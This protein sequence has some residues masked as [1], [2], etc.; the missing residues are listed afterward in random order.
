LSV[1]PRLPR[2]LETLDEGWGDEDDSDLK[3]PDVTP[4]CATSPRR[5]NKKERRELERK[6]RAEQAK[7]EQQRRAARKE[8]KKAA[9]TEPL[10]ASAEPR[11]VADPTPIQKA[12][13][14]RPAPNKKPNGSA[15][16]RKR[17]KGKPVTAPNSTGS[18]A[19][20]AS[21][22]QASSNPKAPASSTAAAPNA[23]ASTS[24]T[25]TRSTSA[26]VPGWVLWIGLAAIV[27]LTLYFV[28][29]R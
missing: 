7:A 8:R 29:R 3:A 4:A 18:S 10:P 11:S 19:A 16:S 17:G 15:K 27:I 26:G 28:F 12:T 6:L 25:T 21:H 2:E 20:R 1:A 24:P 22:G 5:L 14:A 9:R 23:S 13:E